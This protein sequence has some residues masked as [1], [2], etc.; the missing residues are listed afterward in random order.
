MSVLPCPR[1]RL[2][3]KDCLDLDDIS[4][5][6]GEEDESNTAV[7]VYFG[8]LRARPKLNVGSGSGRPRYLSS[9]LQVVGVIAQKVLQSRRMSKICKGKTQAYAAADFV[10]CCELGC[11]SRRKGGG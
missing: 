3:L 2:G 8:E 11:S 9:G 4:V 5:G 1:R 10:V 6:E 7:C